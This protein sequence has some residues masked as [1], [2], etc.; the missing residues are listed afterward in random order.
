M[1]SELIPDVSIPA[2]V[3]VGGLALDSRRAQAGD[4]FLAVPG[5]V[6][7]G[8]AFIDDAISRGV[9][10][11]LYESDGRHGDCP[12]PCISIDNLS[13]EVGRIADRFFGHPSAGL[14]VIGVTGTNGKTSCTHYIA[15]ALCK[16]G[17]KCGVIGTIGTGLPDDLQD[18]GMTTP[19]AIALQGS[20]ARLVELE[21][22]AVALEASSHGLAQGRLNGTA[23]DV[24]VFTNLT[25]DHLDYHESLADYRNAKKRLFEWEGLTAA[26]LNIDD[27][28]GVAL[29][30]AISD[31]V[32]KLT[33]SRN[34]ASADINCTGIS[35]REDGMEI[36]LET[37]WGAQRI[38]TSLIGDFNVS[39]LMAVVG[40]LGVMKFSS[41]EIE[42][43]LSELRTVRGRMDVLRREGLPTVVI[44]YAHTPDALE[45]AIVAARKHCRGRLWCVFGCGGDRDK[46]KRPL[47]GAVASELSDLAVITDDNPRTEPSMSIIEDVLEGVKSREHVSVEPDRAKAI[48]SALAEAQPDDIVLLAGKGHETYQE[49]NG[50]RVDFSDYAEVEKYFTE[51]AMER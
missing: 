33:Y 5:G 51:H 32:T 18:L 19:D 4:L 39:N 43:A 35:F 12:V 11:V 44:D 30:E 23:M 21:A 25:R 20:M 27:E 16:L 47:M 40:V 42:S 49:I 48:A 10:A 38:S 1:L 26:V 50:E 15:Q 8:R 14:L 9:A 22:T 45:K 28:F 2:D 31:R 34:D 3:S 17:R 7:D 29:R 46:G 36:S 41:G 37:P 6:H 24:A 13:A